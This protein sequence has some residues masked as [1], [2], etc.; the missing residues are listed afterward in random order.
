M[1][2]SHCLHERKQCW[3]HLPSSVDGAPHPVSFQTTIWQ[4]HVR[5]RPQHPQCIPAM[6]S[7]RSTAGPRASC[8]PTST[9]CCGLRQGRLGGRGVTIPSLMRGRGGQRA[10]LGSFQGK[11]RRLHPSH[12]WLLFISVAGWKHARAPGTL[13]SIA[14]FQAQQQPGTFL[15]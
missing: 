11:R 5:H 15:K 8:G 6:L 1:A 14:R 9:R 10:G 7:C 2:F 13:S 12:A 4:T 3:P